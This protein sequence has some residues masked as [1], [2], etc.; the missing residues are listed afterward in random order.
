MNGRD[1][2]R[3]KTYSTQIIF[4]STVNYDKFETIIINFTNIMQIIVCWK[5]VK[6]KFRNVQ[7][8]CKDR[9][10]QWVSMSIKSINELNGDDCNGIDIDILI[11]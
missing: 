1:I 10:P 7:N 9:F 11:S 3:L 5:Y 4:T 8:I 2:W 6:R